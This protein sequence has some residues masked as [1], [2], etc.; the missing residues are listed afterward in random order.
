MLSPQRSSRVFFICVVFI[1]CVFFKS[2][3][4]LVLSESVPDHTRMH[5]CTH[6]S[7]AHVYI[8]VHTCTDSCTCIACLH[9]YTR[10]CTRAHTCTHTLP[11]FPSL[12]RSTDHRL[13]RYLCVSCR[14]SL[15]RTLV[16]P[17]TAGPSEPTVHEHRP[18]CICWMDEF[19]ASSEKWVSTGP[20]YISSWRLSSE[21]E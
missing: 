12:S 14:V 1:F 21:A 19:L 4:C 13:A 2:L 6:R 3:T 9:P 8:H 17:L 11:I 10:A 20:G 7:D 16:C 18:G 15:R 5:T